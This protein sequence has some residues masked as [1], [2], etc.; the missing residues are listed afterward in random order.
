MM[1]ASGAAWRMLRDRLGDI[2]GVALDRRLARHREVALLERALDAGEPGQ[3]VGVVLVEDRDLGH[4]H[5]REVLDDRLRLVPVARADVEDVAVEGAA[6][7]LGAGE[8]SPT[9]GTLASVK[10]GSAAAEVGVPT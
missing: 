2:D 5:R 4:A 8:R 3:A 10:I 6:E 9:K 7:Q 1:I